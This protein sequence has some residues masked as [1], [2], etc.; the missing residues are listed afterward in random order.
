[1]NAVITAEWMVIMSRFEAWVIRMMNDY[2]YRKQLMLISMTIL[3]FIFFS[4]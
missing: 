2:E 3:M 4:E 1:M